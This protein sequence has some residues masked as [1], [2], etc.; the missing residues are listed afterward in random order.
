M[1]G[2]DT[3]LGLAGP[4]IVKIRNKIDKIVKNINEAISHIQTYGSHHTECIVS[5]NQKAIQHFIAEL[6]SSCI[7]V[8]ASTRFNDGG[9][10]GL[11]AELGI[12][13]SK[14]HAYGPMGVNEML[15][16]RF[17]VRGKGSIR[18]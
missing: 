15:T 6:D 5:K 14:F 1:A 3:G 7:T 18:S 12:S 13:T 4:I 16:T 11:G 8:N 17:I 10:L 9:Q 2:L